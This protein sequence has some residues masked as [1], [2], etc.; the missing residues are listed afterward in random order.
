MI[1]TP[2]ISTSCKHFLGKPPRSFAAKDVNKF[3]DKVY[4]IEGKTARLNCALF[5]H[6][7]PNFEWFDM[8]PLKRTKGVRP[9]NVDTESKLAACAGKQVC[10]IE[11]VSGTEFTHYVSKS[12]FYN[13]F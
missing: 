8:G 1:V 2:C 12:N 9:D 3:E 6:P 5:G 13:N 10:P 11:N 7:T 4:T